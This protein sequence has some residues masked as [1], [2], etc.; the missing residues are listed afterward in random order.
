MYKFKVYFNHKT[1]NLKII[2]DVNNLTS[3]RSWNLILNLSAIVKHVR[4]Q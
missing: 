4:L 2:A 1:V 3:W